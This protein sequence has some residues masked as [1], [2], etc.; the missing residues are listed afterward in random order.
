[1]ALRLVEI[2]FPERYMSSV[3]SSL[4]DDPSILGFWEQD[5]I[6][7]KAQVRVLVEIG[8][9]E[10][11]LDL[12]EKRVGFTDGFRIVILPVEATLPAP[13]EPEKKE[14]TEAGGKETAKP[15]PG[16]VSRAELLSDLSPGGKITRVYLTTVLLSAIVAA[17][18][19]IRGDVAIIIGAMVIAPLLTPNMALSLA[20]TLGD[21]KLA[22]KS[23]KTNLA[24]VGLA[25]GFSLILGLVIDFDPEG[26]QI[27]ARTRVS[28]GDIVL[29]LAAGCAGALAFTSGVPAGLVG[30]MVAVAL[31]P[32]LVVT[33][34]M[35]GSGNFMPAVGS[36]Q[37]L[38][39]NVICINLTGVATFS[40]QGIHPRSWWEA[41][42]AKRASRRAMLSWGVL[43]LVLVAVILLSR[44]R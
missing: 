40:A 10:S 18:G 23:L 16:R 30:V 22:S 17:I 31:M 4:Q 9:S 37:L 13:E 27:L 42:K 7:E 29:A 8:K 28:M 26:A 32:P 5:L 41:D 43:V 15:L 14:T 38:A 44:S 39:V 19:L 2:V 1:M 25:L 6:G 35:I 33:G 12:M 24:G 3:R 20:T 11:V 36:L 21:K 34:L